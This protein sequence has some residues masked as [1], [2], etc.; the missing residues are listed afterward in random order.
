M[1][2]LIAICLFVLLTGVAYANPFLVCDPQSNVTEYVIRSGG[3][4]V[5]TPYPLHY[6]LQG[7]PD[8]SYTFYVRARNADGDSA[9]VEFSFVLPIQVSTPPEAPTNVRI[10]P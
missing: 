6:D 5:V 2:K 3:Q 10:E 4:E 1:K 8:G 9:E 7:L